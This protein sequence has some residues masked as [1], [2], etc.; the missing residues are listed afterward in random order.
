M[1]D[2]SRFIQDHVLS[3]KSALSSVDQ[4]SGHIIQ[5][6]KLIHSSLL[7]NGTV[8]WCGNGGSASD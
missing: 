4:L 6:Y 7:R 5:A 8:Y 1:E 2:P 3:H